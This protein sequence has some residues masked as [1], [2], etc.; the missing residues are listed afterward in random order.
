MKIR[1]IV[2]ALLGLFTMHTAAFAAGDGNPQTLRVA[3]LPDES[4]SVVIKNNENLK[5]YLQEKLGRKVEHVVI[6]D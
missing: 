5:N 4:P 3:L 1:N 6:T 2:L